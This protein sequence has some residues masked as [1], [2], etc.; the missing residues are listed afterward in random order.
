MKWAIPFVFA[1][2]Y[3]R[4]DQHRS[5][6]VAICPVGPA[7]S[8]HQANRNTSSSVLLAGRW[9]PNGPTWTPRK[10]HRRHEVPA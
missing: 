7:K 3:C 2:R 8:G 1:R 10:I 9:P 4:H 5:T 6:Q